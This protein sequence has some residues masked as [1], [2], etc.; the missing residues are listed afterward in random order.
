LRN[1]FTYAAIISALTIGGLA[2]VLV[3]SGSQDTAML[4]ATLLFVS[5][6]ALPIAAPNFVTGHGK[7]EVGSIAAIGISG[8]VLAGYFLFSGVAFSLA[9][10]GV[11]RSYVWATIILAAGWILTGILISRGSTKRLDDAFPDSETIAARSIITA[12]MDGL[13]ATCSERLFPEINRLS[14][15][16]RFSASELRNTS[17]PES[18]SILEIVR[19]GLS[20]ACR[21]DDMEAFKQSAAAIEQ[22]LQKRDSRLR[23]MRSKV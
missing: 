13:K 15:Q 12:E 21:A 10:I 22:L 19:G 5:A 18:A 9:A 7:S 14:E 16:F 2:L 11:G 8:S 23:V 20:E 1:L 4:I 17:S 3:P 6:V